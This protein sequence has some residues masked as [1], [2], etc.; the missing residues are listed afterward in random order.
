MSEASLND[1]NG[2]SEKSRKIIHV[3]MDAF[4][5]SVEQRD[6]PEF[7]G[8]P[9]VVGGP[10][11]SRG[12]VCTCSYE[13]RK[14]GVHSAMAS[15][16]AYK[17]CPQA[18]FLK[19][20]FEVYKSISQQIREIFHEYTDLVEPLSLDEAY[21]DVTENKKKIPL[22]TDIAKEILNKIRQ[23]T[24]LTASAGVSFNKFLAKVAS[25]FRKPNGLTIITPR[26]ADEFI[27]RLPIG[28]FFGVGKVTE[29]KM[30]SMNIKTGADLKKIDKE[31]LVKHFGKAGIYYYEIV[32]G[33]DNREV[34][35]NRERKSYGEEHTLSKDI[36]DKKEMLEW[37]NRIAG[38][39]EAQM[40]KRKIKGRTITLK[41]KYYN[42]RSVTRSISL[43]EPMCEAALM[44]KY[45]PGLL[46]KTEAGKLKVR[47]L[48]ISLSNIKDI[49]T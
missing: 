28:K 19:P 46:E 8:K 12:V 1:R 23:K 6:H 18:I 34:N 5:A 49:H 15:S 10:P 14:F 3:D 21:L 33:I 37:L 4:Y 30:L 26:M 44:M 43:D 32:N 42:F 16:Q 20:R 40:S 31:E 48:G 39:L 17:L 47:L 2:L 29:K 36:D 45:I 35:P 22:A 13:A 11:Q 9:V 27:D 7:R 38:N 25:G 24:G 41:V